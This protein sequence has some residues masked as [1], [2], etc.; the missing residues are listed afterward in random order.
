M[1]KQGTCFLI[2]PLGQPGS[3]I[4]RRADQ[5]A[6]LLTPVAAARGLTLVRGDAISLQGDVLIQVIGEIVAATVVVADLTGLNPN[7]LYELGIADAFQKPVLRLVQDTQS[8]PFNFRGARIMAV[9]SSVTGELIDD[10]AAAVHAHATRFFDDVVKWDHRV[11]DSVSLAVKALPSMVGMTMLGG[12]EL[13][14]G[15]NGVEKALRAA[16]GNVALFEEKRPRE[17]QP[18][19]KVG[20]VAALISETA[21]L[22]LSFGDWTQ[23]EVD[24]YTSE[25]IDVL[26]E[27]GSP[28]RVV[29]SFGDRTYVAAEPG[30]RAGRRKPEA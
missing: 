18:Q 19:F 22:R 8:L 29:I 10:D 11:V 6:D 25:L 12:Y 21:E 7:V 24:A 15:W 5:I 26:V 30:E 23:E 20:L 13:A 2:T 17:V 28:Y 27:C 4:R 14:T 16:G 3:P 9:R 1:T